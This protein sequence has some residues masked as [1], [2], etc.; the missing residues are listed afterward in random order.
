M[1]AQMSR[2]KG[3]MNANKNIT[4]KKEISHGTRGK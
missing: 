3:E 2:K 1:G 4:E